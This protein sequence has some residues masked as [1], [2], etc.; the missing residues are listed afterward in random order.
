MRSR[1]SHRALSSIVGAM[2]FIVIFGAA[3]A[4]LL[5][6]QDRYAKYINT[7][8]ETLNEEAERLS[9]DLEVKFKALN[10]T[11]VELTIVNKGQV[12]TV[13]D[14]VWVGDKVFSLDLGL[15]PGG[16]SVVLVLNGS[17]INPDSEVFVVTRRGRIFEGEY[18]GYYVKRITI[19]N[20][21][22]NGELHDFQVEIQLTPDNF[23]YS[24]ARW[25]GGDLRF[26]LYSNATG[27]LSYWIESWNTQ[28]TSIVWVKVPS[29]P[30]GGEVDIYMFY[31][32]KDAA[33]ESSFND[34]FDIVGE[35]GLLSVDSRWTETRFLYAYPDSEPPVVV[36][37]PSRLNTTSDSEGVVRIWNVTLAG[38]QACFE[39]YEY[40]THGYETVCWLALRRGQWRIGELYVEVGLE[41]TPTDVTFSSYFSSKPV[42]LTQLQGRDY[43]YARAAHARIEDVTTTGIENMHVEAEET[44]TDGEVGYIAIEEGIANTTF[45]GGLLIQTGIEEDVAVGSSLDVDFESSF[46]TQP[47]VMA[48]IM[49]DTGPL[50]EERIEDVSIDQFSVLIEDENL[51]SGVEDLGWIAVEPFKPIYGR[52]FAP[53]EPIVTVN[54]AEELAYGISYL[55]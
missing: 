2:I 12:F 1:S 17:Q 54:P 24:R 6:M 46:T 18:E 50:R 16:N 26:Y 37:S 15:S 14:H 41:E 43:V 47:A 25:N 23:N 9:E 28:G 55:P 19:E 34:V 5:Y 4:S 22:G 21:P 35:A 45:T 33:S 40:E 52:K 10:S 51:A 3:F 39:E 20:P 31:G 44:V 32:D 49:T 36:A 30:S 29:L 13:V 7:V 27:K 11:A 8:R 38:F 53:I 42:T 48:K